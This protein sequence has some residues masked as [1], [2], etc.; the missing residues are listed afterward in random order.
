MFLF[1]R[2]KI[3]DKTSFLLNYQA[4]DYNKNKKYQN[5]T[6]LR[7]FREFFGQFLAKFDVFDFKLKIICF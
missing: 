6:K 1:L 5:F 2:A 4:A 3:I 7:K